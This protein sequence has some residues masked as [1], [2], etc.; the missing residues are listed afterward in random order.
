MY[1]SQV[2]SVEHLTEYRVEPNP[3]RYSQFVPRL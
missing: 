2:G 3:M 1:Q